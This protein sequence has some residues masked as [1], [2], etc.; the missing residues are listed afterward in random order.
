MSLIRIVLGL[1]LS[2]SASAVNHG[3]LFHQQ[4]LLMQSKNMNGNALKLRVDGT[5]RTQEISFYDQKVDHGSKTSATFKQR[6]FVDSQYADNSQSPVMFIICG[7][8]NC[9]GTGSYSYV[10]HLAKKFKAHLVAL[11][12]RFYGESLPI[13]RLTSESLKHLTLQ[14]AI[15]DL[16]SFQRYMMEVKGLKGKWVAFGGSYAGTLAAFYREKHPELIE[17]A[18]ASSAP[19]LMK[20]EFK[21]YDAH[22]AKIVN[23]TTC[24]DLVRKAVKE[25]E[26]RMVTPEGAAGVKKIFKS[27]EIK[28]DGD[29]LYVVADMLSAAVQYG[30]DKMFCQTLAAGQDLVTAYAQGGL[31][32]LSA[33]GSTPFDISLAVAERLDVTPADNMRQWM[34]QS[35]R[36][37]GWFQVANGNGRDSSRSSK[38]NLTYHNEVCMR[39]Y[40]TPMGKDGALNKKWYLPLFDPATS[41]IIFTNGTNDPWLTLSVVQGGTPSNPDFDL[42][43]MDGSAHCNDL[44]LRTNLA[45]VSAAHVAME[46]IIKVW[47]K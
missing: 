22:V 43:M 9:A 2:L 42:I 41:R 12:H 8:W 15:D 38:I 16:A 25:I 46:E 7:E 40:S 4:S 26:S 5:F 27:S 19:V 17:G 39:L 32:V 10:E 29:F 1:T 28:N 24:G 14:A 3:H 21:E 31:A 20:N 6:Y 45:S 33:M 35:C 23:K 13:K 34:W 37:F 18:L 44:T 30:R 36:E 11:E 47:I